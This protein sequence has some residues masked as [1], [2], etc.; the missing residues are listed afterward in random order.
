MDT[1]TVLETATVELLPLVGV[2]FLVFSFVLVFVSM[3]LLYGVW[4]VVSYLGGIGS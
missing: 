3:A 1:G 2:D 4:L